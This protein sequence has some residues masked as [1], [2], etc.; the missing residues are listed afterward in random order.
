MLACVGVLLLAVCGG[1]G[2]GSLGDPPSK[3]LANP[4]G[5]GARLCDIILPA[6]W[7]DAKNTMSVNCKNVPPT[8]DVS[9]SGLTVVAIDTYDETGNGKSAGNYYIEDTNCAGK[10]FAGV[11]VFSPSFSPPDLRLAPGDVIDFLGSAEEF[12]GPSSGSFG[13]C[14]TLPELTGTLSLRFDGATPEP[15][16]IKDLDLKSYDTARPYLGMLVKMTGEPNVVINGDATASSG[17]YTAALNVGA[18]TASTVPHITNELYDIQTAG[19]ALKDTMTFKSVTGIVTYF[20]GF[21]LAPRSPADF[22]Q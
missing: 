12:I 19:P 8:H 11:T 1:C 10:P 21:H 14:F 16:P 22:E 20:Y 4:F 15:V 6:T 9:S 18:G 3:P 7:E 2:N 17:R 13:S 5:D